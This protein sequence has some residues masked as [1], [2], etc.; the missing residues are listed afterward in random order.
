MS[1]MVTLNIDGREIRAAAG[2]TLME[3]ARE[4]NIH[5]P[6]LCSNLELEPYGACRMCIVEVTHG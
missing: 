1:Q 6:N 2:T 3:A 4:V 5:I